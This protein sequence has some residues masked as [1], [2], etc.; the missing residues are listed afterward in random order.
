MI[1]ARGD[2]LEFFWSFNSRL[3]SKFAVDVSL[4]FIFPTLNTLARNSSLVCLRLFIVVAKQ[5]E[6]AIILKDNQTIRK[7]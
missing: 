2:G 1:F 5:G 4:L 6:A 7:Y 3:E